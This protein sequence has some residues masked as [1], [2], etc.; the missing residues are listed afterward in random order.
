MSN[1]RLRICLFS[2]Y[3]PNHFGGGERYLFSV[4]EFLSRNHDVSIALP[5][6][7]VTS[8]EEAKIRAKY[9]EFLQLNLHAVRFIPS[10]FRTG[11][12]FLEKLLWTKQ[13][14]IIY[15]QTDGSLFFSLAKRNILHIQIPFTTP[16]E[17]LINRLKLKNW[18]VK[19]TN[20]NFTKEVIERVWKTKVQVVHHPFVDT[21]IY[22]PATKK[23]KIILHVGRFFSHLHTKKQDIL[24]NAF[25]KLVD[26]H[27]KEMKNWKLVMIGGVEDEIYAKKVATLAEG[28]PIKIIHDAS[29][30]TVKS[31]YA[32]AKIYWHAT[33]FTVDEFLNPMAVEHFGISTLEA[34]SSGA[35]P[36]VINK[37]GQKELVEHGI[38]GFLWNELEALEDRTLACVTGEVD[39]EAMGTRAR[40]KAMTFSP[41]HFYNQLNQMIGVDE[42]VL[43]ELKTHI[44]VIIPTYNG[45]DLLKRHLE[46]VVHCM[47]EHDELV[48]VDDASTDDTIE[49]LTKRLGLQKDEDRAEFHEY[50]YRGK[51]ESENKDIDVTLIQ[52][53]ENERFG[54]TCN[55]GVRLSKHDLIFVVNN[56]VRPDPH[57]F[58]QLV[59]Y[60]INHQSA[61]HQV[62]GVGC[63]E[64]EGERNSQQ[65]KDGK[66]K[67]WFERGLFVHS[68]ADNFT[69]GN[70]AWVSGGSGLYS[71]QKWEEI[72]GF[73]SR[74]Y[75]A[76]W[77]DIDLGYR[78]RKKGWKVLFDAEAV[79][80]HHH[81]TT[82]Q[83]AFGQENMDVMSLK[84]NI[85]FTWIHSSIIQKLQFFLWLPYHLTFTNYRT[86]G[87]F[88]RGLFKLIFHLI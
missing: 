25:K 73:D 16:Q 88:G 76:Y 37:G 60:F 40:E 49:W 50:I 79:V 57:L 14:D 38:T 55:K 8:V 59:P 74:F 3:V 28:Y 32:M 12:N 68:K 39:I 33:G 48:I 26:E 24:V 63:L 51:W 53:K 66:N 77:E 15:Y 42:F 80:E 81:E 29:T 47:R 72:G 54:S 21:K 36:I 58:S 35:V 22:Q 84:N 20:S 5:T 62:F 9:Q 71:K 10:P 27:P 67:L 18:H 41:E 6:D 31:Y 82:N 19:N 13:F 52:N 43:P 64:I 34:M 44:S 45:K 61:A 86:R 7:S 78:A 17:G 65:K 70:T 83:A 85:L 46:S 69:S 11:S 87:R 75:P 4:A 23:S 1:T 2:P 56:D 30:E